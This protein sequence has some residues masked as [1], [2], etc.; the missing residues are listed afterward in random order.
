MDTDD[1]VILSIIVAEVFTS[2]EEICDSMERLYTREHR[3]DDVD[4]DSLCNIIILC[5][6]VE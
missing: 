5:S 3:Y 6:V 1:D 4:D 2:Y